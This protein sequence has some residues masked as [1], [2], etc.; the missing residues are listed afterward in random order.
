MAP[1]I[2][3]ASVTDNTVV[4]NWKVLYDGGST[5]K[6][7]TLYYKSNDDSWKSIRLPANFQSYTLKNLLCGHSYTAYITAYNDIGTSEAGPNVS[8]RIPGQGW[9]LISSRFSL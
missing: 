4:V 8:A 3:V 9:Y 6:G 5:I 1:N 2:T 7:Y